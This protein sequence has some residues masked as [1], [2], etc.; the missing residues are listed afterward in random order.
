MAFPTNVL[1]LASAIG[2]QFLA[3]AWGGTVGMA[4]GLNQILADL[5]AV[6]GKI[7]T[8]ASTPTNKTMLGGNGT[9]T[10]AWTASPTV[11]GSVTA[12]AGI[13][14]GTTGA[15][16]GEVK[17]T[18]GTFSGGVN[19]GT[20]GAGTGEVKTSAA[21]KA[22]AGIYPSG[23]ALMFASVPAASATVA[24]TGIALI[25]ASPRAG[26]VRV[27]DQTVNLGAV[28]TVNGAA[29]TTSLHSGSATNFGV[30]L[31]NDS[32]IHCVYNGGNYSL[33]NGY[34]VSHVLY[35]WFEG[36]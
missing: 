26:F 12:E 36:F 9:G 32:K 10:S 18:T 25:G 3:T 16:T 13:N 29:N 23:Q 14:A 33:Y 22:G 19:A 1:A 7:G 15:A 21:V 5:I 8:G 11:S 28:F 30:S 34:A 17:A 4:A 6:E 31:A 2:S 35:A 27:Y 20:T 24:A